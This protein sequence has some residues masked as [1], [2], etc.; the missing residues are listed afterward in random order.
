MDS[1]EEQAEAH[2][3]LALVTFSRTAVRI[4][5]QTLFYMDPDLLFDFDGSIY[6]RTFSYI[7]GSPFFNL[8]SFFR[9]YSILAAHGRV[10]FTEKEKAKIKTKG[11]LKL[12]VEIVYMCNVVIY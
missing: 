1:P 9:L 10:Y 6:L 11:V 7:Y 5:T 2:Y 4:K 3:H 12:L 8:R